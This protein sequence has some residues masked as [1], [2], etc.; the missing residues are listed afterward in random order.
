MFLPGQA[1]NFYKLFTTNYGLVA[2]V[3]V[4]AIVFAAAW[5]V[6]VA[7]AAAVCVCVLM[8]V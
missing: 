7:V 3:M 8:F 5:G 4:A 1:R 2:V 6:R